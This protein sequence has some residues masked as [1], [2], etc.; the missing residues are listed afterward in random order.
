MHLREDLF[1]LLNSTKKNG[2]GLGLWL[3]QQIMARH[4]GLLWHED[5]KGGGATFVMELPAS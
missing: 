5:T 4:G 2:M 1:E 3:C